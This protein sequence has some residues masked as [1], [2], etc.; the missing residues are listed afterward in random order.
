VST[1]AVG[2]LVQR[3]ILVAT[4]FSV[5]AVLACARGSLRGQP[6]LVA[7]SVPLYYLALLGKEHAVMLPGALLAVVFVLHANWKAQLWRY[8]Y[9]WAGH[10]LLA[11]LVV[12]A[13]AGLLGQIYEPTTDQ[14]LVKPPQWAYP[15]SVL[16]QS[17]LYFKYLMHWLLPQPRWMSIDMQIA[18][19]GTV[20]PGYLLGLVAYIAMGAG[21]IYLMSRRG[22]AGLLGFSLFY[23]WV[24]F[25]TEF[26]TVRIQE[27]FVLYRSY[28]WAAGLFC[29]VPVVFKRVELRSAVTMVVLL[30]A[31]LFVVAME[32][33]TVLSLPLFVWD[34]A[35]KLVKGENALPGAYRIYYN[36]GY[37]YW[38][39]G[40]AEPAKQDFKKA[41]ELNPRF[42]DAYGNLGALYA[43]QKEWENARSMLQ[44]A[45]DVAA[46]SGR[47][48][49]TAQ[50]NLG[51]VQANNGEWDAALSSFTQAI[52]L[53]QRDGHPPTGR[54]VLERAKVHEHLGH[55]QEAQADYAWSCR[56]DKRGCEKAEAL[57]KAGQA[58]SSGA[59]HKAP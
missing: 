50:G 12:M 13:K 58:G 35:A 56:I 30:A 4:L 57:Q 49:S 32:R 44:Q 10:F 22:L 24:M 46:R 40:M 39:Q 41:I 54:D 26:S 55:L 52:E 34:D 42:A 33:L 17:G 31:G 48:Y 14:M 2:Y 5:L 3:S 8:R 29:A 11:V 38:N 53:D 28:L 18:L 21:S 36:R 45:I 9:V 20:Q 19:A 25:W 7:S 37:E 6:W 23:P 27:I 59:G 47:G 16:T 15:L 1:Y 43:N 51:L